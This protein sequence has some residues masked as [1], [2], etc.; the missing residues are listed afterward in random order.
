MYAKCILDMLSIPTAE[1]F[2]VVLLFLQC[3]LLWLVLLFRL[4]EIL[5]FL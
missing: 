2:Q 1:E 5:V 3:P 4:I